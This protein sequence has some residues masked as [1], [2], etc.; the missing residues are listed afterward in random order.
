MRSAPRRACC[1]RARCAAWTGC[2][3]RAARRRSS[4][5]LDVGPLFSRFAHDVVLLIAALVCLARARLVAAAERLA[6][7]LIG[8]GVLAWTFGE[9]YYTAV[10]WTRRELA[11]PVAR[12]RRLPAL[13]AARARRHRSLLL[14]ARARARA[15]TR[16][17]VDGL[18]RRARRRRAQRR[19][20]LRDRARQ[21]RRATPLAVATEPRLPVIDLVLLGVVVGA[22]AGTGWRLDRT[23]VLLA[24]GIVDLLAGRLA[25]P[26][27]APPQ[28]TY[29][30]G[31]WFDA[32]WW[33]RPGR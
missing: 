24:A 3:V 2:S 16:C 4:P 1:P 18:D 8:A 25:L 27:A 21:R 23:W 10:L 22:L 29:E 6:W 33:A 20:R 12:R 9:I 11:D 5:G 7:L 14:R 32:G 17:W 13:P 31:G 28:G 30:A 19:D 15:A 26:R